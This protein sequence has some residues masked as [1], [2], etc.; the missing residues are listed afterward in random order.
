MPS[1]V[2]RQAIHLPWPR[3][4]LCFCPYVNQPAPQTGYRCHNGLPVL[5]ELP[6]AWFR[7]KSW[8][9]L[10]LLLLALELNH[11]LVLKIKEP[12]AELCSFKLCVLKYSLVL[13]VTKNDPGWGLRTGGLWYCG[14]CKIT[15]D[16]T[17]PKKNRKH[18]AHSRAYS[19][20]QWLLSCQQFFF[21]P[22]IHVLLHPPCLH[23][24][25][26][27]EQ[28]AFSRVRMPLYPHGIQWRRNNVE[29]DL[30]DRRQI[31]LRE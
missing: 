1:L 24:G 21:L 11:P 3:L 4:S 28:M 30:L 29:T 5:E 17:P 18:P 12:V 15:W 23:P 19:V 9:L 10:Y 22:L 27:P 25:N 20:H 26:R 7:R 31:K 8:P 14:T 2:P 13:T 6:S 16:H